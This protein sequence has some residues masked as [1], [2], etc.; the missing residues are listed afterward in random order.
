M[1]KW[2]PENTG[3]SGVI[4]SAKVTRC[5]LPSF[6]QTLGSTCPRGS[7]RAQFSM[8]LQVGHGPQ[9]ASPGHCQAPA[10]STPLPLGG[11]ACP[12]LEEATHGR[13]PR[14]N[15]HSTEA[16]ELQC[17]SLNHAHVQAPTA[18]K[19]GGAHTN[20]AQETGHR[21]TKPGPNR[22]PYTLCASP[23]L[24]TTGP[25][26]AVRIPQRLTRQPGRGTICCVHGTAGVTDV[27]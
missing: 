8:G 20:R 12:H 23:A 2:K 15:A 18:P 5:P 9:V 27:P 3:F 16:P 14:A 19:P 21:H 13:C 4:P 22:P 11:S 1:G 26:P 25:C 7:A 6:L 17:Q 24:P 10:P